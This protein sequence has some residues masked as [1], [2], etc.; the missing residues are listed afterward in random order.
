[1]AWRSSRTLRVLPQFTSNPDTARHRHL[2][3]R[4]I[5]THR[6]DIGG[7]PGVI[8]PLPFRP[9][10]SVLPLSV[11]DSRVVMSMSLLVAAA[12]LLA[13]L[14]V[15]S[16]QSSTFSWQF[17][18]LSVRVTRTLRDDLSEADGLHLPAV[19]SEHAAS[20]RLLED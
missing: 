8:L 2:S 5:R 9:S 3:L 20:V 7:W 13:A 12:A 6:T 16:A 10:L 19:G 14:P 15:A 17:A 18:N 4:S 11:S 1:M